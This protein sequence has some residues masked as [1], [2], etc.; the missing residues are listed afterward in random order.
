MHAIARFLNSSSV[1]IPYE[2]SGFT[3]YS[4]GTASKLS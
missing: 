4:A 1:T 3:P 2:L